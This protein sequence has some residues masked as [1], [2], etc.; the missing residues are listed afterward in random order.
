MPLPAPAPRKP[1]HNRTIVCEG[2]HREDGLWDIE[3]RLVDTKSYAFANTWR[4]EVQ[5]GEPLHEMLVR[6]TVDNDFTVVAVETASDHTPHRE[7]GAILPNFQRLVGLRI[8]PGWSRRVKELTGGVEGCAHHVELVNLLATVAFQTIG[9]L[10]AHYRKQ[11][12]VTE[13]GG[14]K[15]FLVDSCHI[16]RADGEWA[17]AFAA[18]PNGTLGDR[19]APVQTPMG[20]ESASN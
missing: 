11:A 20:D 8:G 7:C 14:A 3:G 6:L 15:A 5:P 16:W 2:F 9:P 10:L 4:S 17:K 19:Q 1:I 18:D 13:Q 12:G